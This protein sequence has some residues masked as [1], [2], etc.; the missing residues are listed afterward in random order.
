MYHLSVKETAFGARSYCDYN[1]ALKSTKHE[2]TLNQPPHHTQDTSCK[3]QNLSKKLKPRARNHGRKLHTVK[4]QTHV[5]QD[6]R[7]GDARGI[8]RT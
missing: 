8:E 2:R 5:A 1:D 4:K 6:Q 3:H 7:T